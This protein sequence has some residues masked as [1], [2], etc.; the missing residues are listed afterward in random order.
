[1]ADL[2]SYAASGYLYSALGARWS[3]FSSFAIASAGGLIVTI[4]GLQHQDSWTFVPLVFFSRIG[5]SFAFNII[6]VAH[7][8]LF[9]I[10]FSTTSLGF[11]NF[12]ARV[13]S[14]SS[15]LFA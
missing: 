15:S 1:M 11:C 5:I 10:L 14:A 12:F 2:L 7:A 8:P 3:L 6:Y 9:P 13:F 4:Y